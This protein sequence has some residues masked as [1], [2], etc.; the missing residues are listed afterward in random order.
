MLCQDDSG[1]WQALPYEIASAFVRTL[2]IHMHQLNTTK[3]T[4]TL[5]L[6][7]DPSEEKEKTQKAR[8]E[9][10]SLLHY[11]RWIIMNARTGQLAT[12]DWISKNVVR[13][14]TNQI[15]WRSKTNKNSA[16]WVMSFFFQAEGTEAL[17]QLKLASAAPTRRV[18]CWDIRGGAER[19]NK[20]ATILVGYES[21]MGELDEEESEAESEETAVGDEAGLEGQYLEL[22]HV[23]V[24]IFVCTRS[25]R[26]TYCLTMYSYILYTICLQCRTEILRD[27]KNRH[28]TL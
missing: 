4:H 14:A 21:L 17:L 24:P 28:I 8:D 11:E 2:A 3:N 10:V 22:V 15:S 20:I 19:S 1:E 25:A 16:P 23:S 27:A 12:Q 18:R 5:L 9:H 7:E 6:E 13:S 26:L